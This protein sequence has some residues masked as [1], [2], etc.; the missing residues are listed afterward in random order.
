[1]ENRDSGISRP[2]VGDEQIQ[3]YSL[4]DTADDVAAVINDIGEP[5]HLIGASMG[6]F[7]VRWAAV[8]HPDKIK[9]LTVVMS[10]SGAG[11]Q[12][13]GPQMSKAAAD[14]VS[15]YL[16]HRSRDEQIA[17]NLDIWRWSWG[18]KYP[19]PA[20]WII[21]CLGHAY[22]RSYNPEGNARLLHA[23]ISTQGLWDAQKKISCPTLVMHGG[24]D[25][26]FS[27]EHGEAIA[28]RIHNAELWLDQ[29]MGHIMHQEQ[30]EDMASRVAK[31]AGLTLR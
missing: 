26:V 7:I 11:P 1:M 18:N 14:E 8:R 23:L 13:N 3:P 20:E 30:W 6:G 22:D 5:V 19:F 15:G 29:K 21:E 2:T 24:E 12:D 27:Q 16:Q 31:L 17:W 10:G 4:K 28:A 9:T 25:P